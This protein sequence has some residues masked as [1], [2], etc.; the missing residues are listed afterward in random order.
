MRVNLT[1]LFKSLGSVEDVKRSTRSVSVILFKGWQIIYQ[2]IHDPFCVDTRIGAEKTGLTPD[3][4]QEFTVYLLKTNMVTRRLKENK[5]GNQE[6][7]W[8]MSR[9]A[10]DIIHIWGRVLWH[11]ELYTPLQLSL[12]LLP[13]AL[14]RSLT[15]SHRN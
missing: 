5:E 8:A 3:T 12:N 9:N 7:M 4:T 6:T 15:W 14:T 2:H 1:P 10:E 11:Y 13:G